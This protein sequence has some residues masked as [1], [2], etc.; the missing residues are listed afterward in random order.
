MGFFTR[1]SLFVL[2]LGIWIFV[3]HGYS[4][5][6]VHHPQALFAIF[7]MVLPFSPSG[8]RLSVDALIR[9]RRAGGR[10]ISR[11]GT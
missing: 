5:A 11:T 2:A 6:D 9:R 4:Y 3:S 7:L 10:A 1:T 8:D